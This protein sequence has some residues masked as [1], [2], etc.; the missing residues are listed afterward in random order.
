MPQTIYLF[1]TYHKST[2][3][4][5][6]N[7][8][9]FRI[10]G[11]A[12]PK[13]LL[14]YSSTTENRVTFNSCNLARTRWDDVK[15][16][17]DP[18]RNLFTVHRTNTIGCVRRWCKLTTKFYSFFLDPTHTSRWSKENSKITLTHLVGR[19]RSFPMWNKAS[20]RGEK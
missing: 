11:F 9:K 17:L 6:R 1:H 7:L 18:R 19:L 2:P 8:S 13:Y 15:R 16:I 4:K 3:T 14:V 10:H 20:R 5:C 12:F